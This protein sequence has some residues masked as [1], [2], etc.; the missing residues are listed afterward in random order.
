MP[1]VLFVCSSDRTR[2]PLAAAAFTAAAQKAGLTDWE[3]D[4]AGIRAQHGQMIAP[5]VRIVLGERGLEPRRIGVQLLTPKLIKGADL[6]ICMTSDQEKEVTKKYAPA[7]YKTKTLMSLSA[8]PIDLFDPNHL[9]V[10][11]YRQCLELMI[12]ALEELA[13][14]LA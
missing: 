5:E 4:S 12:P 14:R 13:Q 9:S 6:L 7:R 8:N 1:K 2:G 10:E 11:K 3:C